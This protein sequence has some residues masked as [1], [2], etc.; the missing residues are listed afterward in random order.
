ME[1]GI[2]SNV[3]AK[4]ASA[5][6][7]SGAG[8]HGAV[9]QKFAGGL[10]G[11]GTMTTKKLVASI[12][13]AR[14]QLVGAEPTLGALKSELEGLITVLKE[15]GVRKTL[16]ADIELL[17]DLVLRH[18]ETSIA[19]FES[20]V[21]SVASASRQPDRGAT[22]VDRKQLVASYLHRLEAA[23]GNDEIFLPLHRE[24]SADK[25][26][27]KEIAIEIASRFLAPLPPSTTRPKAL[28]KVLY[29]HEKLM[30]SQ[31]A[32]SSIGGKAYA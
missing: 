13:K 30:E 11:G 22:P 18:R 5:L 32:S 24:L 15:A 6:V 27:T 25:R 16:V 21:R 3:L 12:D 14:L 28:K 7:V 8:E 1:I 4:F 17:L 9:L 26:V 29:R 31:A 23:L 2:V 20:L 10:A 19:E